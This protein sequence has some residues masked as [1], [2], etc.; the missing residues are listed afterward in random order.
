MLQMPKLLHLLQM[1]GLVLKRG[2]I[3]VLPVPRHPKEIAGIISFPYPCSAPFMVW[4]S[5]V[6]MIVNEL[7]CKIVAP[8]LAFGNS[9]F[10]IGPANMHIPT[11]H[12]KPINIEI[13]NEN[14]VF[15]VIVFLS[16]LAFAADIVGTRAVANATFIESGKL[17]SISTF[18]PKI[19]YC[20][21]ASFSGKNC[22]RLLTTVNESMFLLSDDII[23][24][25]AI[26]A[27][28]SNTFLM[29]VFTLSYL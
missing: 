3:S 23:A 12:G 25:N 14:D 10:K 9:K 4:S 22:F 16:F 24:V 18:P 29:I 28:T 20:A 11:V 13:S 8:A 15:S 27:D 6:K 26:G 17:V 1:L 5:I 19:P 7:I 21:N 2:L